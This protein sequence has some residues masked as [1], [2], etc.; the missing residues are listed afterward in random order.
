[1]ELHTIEKDIAAA[2]KKHFDEKFKPTW[3]CIVGRNFGATA[4]V[5]WRVTT[6]CPRTGVTLLLEEGGT[7]IWR[8]Y[9]MQGR[10]SPMKAVILSTSTL[11]SGHGTTAL[12]LRA[13]FSLNVSPNVKAKRTLYKSDWSVP[14]G[15][16]NFHLL[17]RR[18]SSYSALQVRMMPCLKGDLPLSVI[19]QNLLQ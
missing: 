10:M 13:G 14:I 17:Q 8:K 12:L 1:M 19:L 7:D 16:L 6:G 5:P 9:S 2:I 15:A 4:N 11:V 18:S 3:H